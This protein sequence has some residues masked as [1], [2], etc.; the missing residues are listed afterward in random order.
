MSR[1]MIAAVVVVALVA[2]GGAFVLSQ[3]GQPVVVGPNPTTEASAS[4]SQ[5]AVAVPSDTPAPTPLTSVEPSPPVGQSLEMTWTELSLA[6]RAPKIE[7]LGNQFVHVDEES[8]VVQT[9]TDGFSWHVLQPGDPD[10]GY[11]DLIRDVRDDGL[12]TWGDDIVRWWNPEEGPEI[13]GKPPITARDIVRIVR[14]GAATD[15][16]PFKGR[17]QSLAFGPAGIVATVASDLDWDAWVTKKLGVKSNNAWV[18]HQRGVDFRDGIME[19]KFDNRPTLRV[20]WA[21]EGFEPGDFMYGGFGWFSPDGEQWTQIPGYLT[22]FTFGEVIGVSDGFIAEGDIP[23]GGKCSLPDGCGPLWHSTDGLTWRNLGPTP[24]RENLSMQPWKGGALVTDEFGIFDFW[25][26]Q[27][28][29]ELPMAA[30]IRAAKKG[31]DPD[32]NTAFGT[33]PLG[34]VRVTLCRETGGVACPPD[35]SK[36]EVLVTRDG[37]DWAIGRIPAAMAADGSLFYGGPAIAVGER[38]VLVTL[39]SGRAEERIPSLW[40]GKLEP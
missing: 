26:S 29:S 20:V 12:V 33:G 24:E 27:G 10:P 19:I 37:V 2:L 34:I 23:E 4:P 9:S 21:D 18:M 8:G 15:T 31:K 6:E 16:T 3:R 40:L 30:E 25:T 32:F 1:T 17:I 35:G 14:S 11:L 28:R 39:W 7:W 22:E 13:A 5:P 38:S 36:N